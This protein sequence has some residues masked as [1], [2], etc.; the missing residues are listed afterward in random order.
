[1]KPTQREQGRGGSGPLS[2]I[3]GAPLAAEVSG[4]RWIVECPYCPGAEFA[5]EANPNF[6]CDNCGNKANGFA[7]RPVTFPKA[8]HAIEAAL[9]SREQGRQHWK[10]GETVAQLL[11][12]NAAD[13]AQR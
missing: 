13:K 4:G 5:S 10:P 9:D 2:R 1:V 7:W 6:I 12:E 11:A 3:A 8:I